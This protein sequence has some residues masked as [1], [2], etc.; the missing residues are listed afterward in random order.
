MKALLTVLGGIPRL[1]FPPNYRQ[2]L[3]CRQGVPQ[4]DSPSRL[5]ARAD[6]TRMGLVVGT[7]RNEIAISDSK[8]GL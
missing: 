2:A 5:N 4:K 7:S 1:A 6:V 8:M 3:G